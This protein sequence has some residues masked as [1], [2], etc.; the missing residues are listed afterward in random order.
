M[1]ELA[2]AI[3]E[4][5]SNRASERLEQKDSQALERHRL[6]DEEMRGR[7]TVAKRER[8]LITHGAAP[9]L[10]RT[11]L[12]TG[13][14]SREQRRHAD[15]NMRPRC[16]SPARPQQQNRHMPH[17]KRSWSAMSEG[18]ADLQTKVVRGV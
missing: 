3:R 16:G 7:W 2:K 4:Q 14:H 1:R 18:L 8:A 13:H 11:R 10:S 17:E 6:L 5:P 12:R 15:A 9:W